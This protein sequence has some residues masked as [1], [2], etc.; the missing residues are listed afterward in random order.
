MLP[1]SDAMGSEHEPARGEVGASS[2]PAGVAMT[3]I[4]DKGGSNGRM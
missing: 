1:R 2:F 4:H 3:G